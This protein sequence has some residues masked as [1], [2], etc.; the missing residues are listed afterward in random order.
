MDGVDDVDVA[1]EAGL[2]RHPFVTTSDFDFELAV[3]IVVV[4]T[5]VFEDFVDAGGI[6][7]GVEV[8][9][10]DHAG[11]DLGEVRLF[12][13]GHCPDRLIEDH[14]SEVMKGDVDGVIF[15]G[16]DASR[17]VDQVGDGF[18]FN[19]FQEL[20]GF[21]SLPLGLPPTGRAVVGMK[22]TNAQPCG[23]V[24]VDAFAG[25]AA[26]LARPGDADGPK[27][28]PVNAMLGKRRPG[29]VRQPRQRCGCGSDGSV[30]QEGAAVYGSLDHWFI[31]RPRA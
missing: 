23:A 13:P 3:T 19:K 29:G 17:R 22:D 18:A 15:C 9:E 20:L 6:V 8:I 25:V 16:A 28:N 27:F 4:P 10:V 5:T 7:C 12:G 11:V 24:T 14:A 2:G 26:D 21:A 31:L 1:L 30:T